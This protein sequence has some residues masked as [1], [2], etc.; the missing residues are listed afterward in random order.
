LYRAIYENETFKMGDNIHLNACVGNNGFIDLYTYQCGYYE[1]T[2]DLIN[3]VKKS[4]HKADLLIFPIVYSARHTIELF[5]KNQLF[6]L[7]HINSKAQGKKFES[8]IVNTHS[9]KELWE[10][11]KNLSA[12]DIRYKIYTNDL[13]EYILDFCEVDNTGETFRY[14]FDHEEIRHLTDLAC[15]N[16]DIFERRFVKLYE[17][18]DELGYLTDF[19][20]EE[21]NEGTVVQNLSRQQIKEIALELPVKKDWTKSNF[22]IIKKKICKKYDISS[23]TFSKALSL[24]QAHKEFASYIGLEV[25]L[26]DINNDQLKEYIVLYKRYCNDFEKGKYLEVKNDYTNSIC[27]KFKPDAIQSLATLFDIGYFNLYPEA[28]ERVIK[29]KASQDLFSIVFD[30]LLGGVVLEKI[31]IALEKLGQKTLLKTFE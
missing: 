14:P 4:P 5:I 13:D 2:I 28:Y 23:N 1:A 6:N 10:D 11:F 22:K 3:I 8:R 17:I 30:E 25:P 21:Y 18:I 26:N 20:F 16:I 19:L 24:I 12:V 7:K 9:I 27:K 15:I 29:E 31:K